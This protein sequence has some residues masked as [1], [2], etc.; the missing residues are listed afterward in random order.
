M[1]LATP[2]HIEGQTDS[3]TT[4]FSTITHTPP[5][6]PPAMAAKPMNNTTLAFHATPSPL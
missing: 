1:T 3:L 4:Y 6:S 2:I 5:A